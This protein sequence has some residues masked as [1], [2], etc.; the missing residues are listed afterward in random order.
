MKH[1]G[2]VVAV[3]VVS[4]LILPLVPPGGTSPVQ[5]QVA[6]SAAPSAPQAAAALGLGY[7]WHTFYGVADSVGQLRTVGVD[8]AGNVYVAG[9]ISRTW[10]SPLHEH[11]GGYDAVVIKLNGLGAYQWHTFYGASPTESEDGDDEAVGIAV[12][13]AG[14]VYVAG[15]S[16][17]TWQG[18]GDT[19][20][21]NPHTGTENMVV[22]KL[23]SAGAYQWHTFYQPGRAN[24]IALD[25]AGNVLITGYSAFEWGTPLHSAAD[26]GHLV[27]LK[28]DG[29]G[30][31]Q[32]HTYYGG[33][34]G[35][36][37][38]AGYGVA[39]DS[40]SNVYVTGTATYPWLGDGG[41]APLSPFSGGEG[42]STDIAILKLSANGAYQ[43]HTFAGADGT[44]DLNNGIAWRAGSLVVVGQSANTW[45]APLNPNAG[46]TDIAVLQLSGNG[47]RQWNTFYGSTASDVGSSVGIKADGSIYVSG[48]SA[49]SWL[50]DDGASPSHP[51]SGT[52]GAD[53]VVLK[54]DGSGR[55]RRHT[56]YGDA[57]THDYGFGI[58]VDNNYALFIPGTSESTWPGDGGIAP[59]HPHSGNLDG[60]GFV[61]KLDDW[62]H[63]IYIPLIIR[64]Q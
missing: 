58:A 22:L 29:N 49:A 33:D 30:A 20:P 64:G 52:G 12:D 9:H 18:P 23:D 43:W 39:T 47:Q 27:V 11:S 24:A 16:D 13:A 59:L 6:A 28:L 14:N 41:A 40:A 17:R 57:D 7:Q 2:V 19:G 31:Y 45:G 10:G 42:Y 8:G 25:G 62:I 32:W 36:G 3:V 46:E 51:Y 61:L 5:A 26:T 4:V 35:A 48:S 37:D 21:L 60:D 38:E 50:G 44:D 53:I 34:V 15:Y 54:L 55:Y 1:S 63:R 56:F